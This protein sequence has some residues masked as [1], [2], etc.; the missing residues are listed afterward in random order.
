METKNKV[1]CLA[2]EIGSV[3][4]SQ[5]GLEMYACQPGEFDWI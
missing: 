4:A 3:L 5:I 1:M 2:S